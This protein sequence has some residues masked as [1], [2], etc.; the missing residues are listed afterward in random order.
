MR[1]QLQ[2]IPLRGIVRMLYNFFLHHIVSI[3]IDAANQTHLV[4]LA[5]YSD[6]VKGMV[7]DFFK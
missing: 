2:T 3:H 1:L 4:Q 6:F 7:Y 5:L